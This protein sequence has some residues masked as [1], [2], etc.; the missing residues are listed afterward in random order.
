MRQYAWF[1]FHGGC[2]HLVTANAPDPDRKWANRFLALSDWTA[3]GWIIDGPYGKEPTIRH[4]LN[5][6]F[7]GYGLLRTIH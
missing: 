1:D 7:C 3:E 5:R 4:N 2:W 6:H